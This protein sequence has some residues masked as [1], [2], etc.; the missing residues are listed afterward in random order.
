MNH[1]QTTHD[2]HIS[3]SSSSDK[4]YRVGVHVGS[5]STDVV[6]YD[7]DSRAVLVAK[8]PTQ[9]D[10]TGQCIQTMLKQSGISV[11]QIR[12][13][14]L[15]TRAGEDALLQRQGDRVLLLATAGV[16]DILHIGRGNRTRIIDPRYRKPTPLVP[17]EDIVEIPGRIDAAGS[18]V[19][20]LGEGLI[21]AAAR[22]AR[23]NGIESIA[24]AFLFSYL[25]PEHELRAAAIV[26]EEMGEV[27]IALS[28]RVAR[29]WSEYERTS[30]TVAEAYAA[31]VVRRYL[32]QLEDAL[33][34]DHN[35][36]PIRLM[37]A[38]GGTASAAAGRSLMLP[39]F[40]SRSAGSAIGAQWLSRHLNRPNIVCLDLGGTTCSVSLIVDGQVRTSTETDLDGIP[41]LLP[42][43][44]TRSIGVEVELEAVA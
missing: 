22:R 30:S 18:E 7:H 10:D 43:I 25:N 42:A 29:E 19:E 34:A 13:L 26:S 28:H 5:T 2:D 8:A 12:E 14:V 23:A 40:T 4:Q 27:S 9:T 31:P 1:S 15:T 20:G 32:D 37:R 39:S 17:R 44:D 41:L 38:S 35:V 36:L 21:R 24:I 33:R 11:T 16:A 6:A 3:T